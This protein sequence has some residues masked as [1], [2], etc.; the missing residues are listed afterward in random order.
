M[1]YDGAR[2]AWLIR[3]RRGCGSQ[4]VTCWLRDWILDASDAKSIVQSPRLALAGDSVRGSHR[5][6]TCHVA[7]EIEMGISGEACV[8]TSACVVP[9]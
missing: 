1:K 3:K 4:Y 2:L 6:S 9:A 7:L 5:G 8:V